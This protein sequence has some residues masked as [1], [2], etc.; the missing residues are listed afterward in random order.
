MIP[1]SARVAL[2]MV[3]TTTTALP[4]SRTRSPVK[5]LIRWWMIGAVMLLASAVVVVIT[6]RLLRVGLL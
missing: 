3:D 5:P 4:R 6:V 2:H 1:K